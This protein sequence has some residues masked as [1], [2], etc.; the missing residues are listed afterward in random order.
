MNKSAIFSQDKLHRFVLTRVWDDTLPKAMC[1][2][3]NPSTANEEKD[4]STIRYLVKVLVSC[5]YGGLTMVNL[6]S[7][8][9]S[10]P[11]NL[12][13]SHFNTRYPNPAN[14]SWIDESVKDCQAII[15]CW[16]DFAQAHIKARE[17]QK[18]FPS[19]LCFGKSKKGNPY[20]P[21]RMARS[22]ILAERVTTKTFR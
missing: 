20:H 8:I 2:G 10:D 12:L 3:L 22:G 4:D 7:Y 11:T 21:Q 14:E 16:G 15:F 19:A 1:I 6:F 9:T 17:I 13:D 5:G 18:R